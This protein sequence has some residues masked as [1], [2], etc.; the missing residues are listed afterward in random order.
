[1]VHQ[2]REALRNVP[3]AAEVVVLDANGART[4][5]DSAW[6]VSPFPHDTRTLPVVI[7]SPN[8]WLPVTEGD[9]C[10]AS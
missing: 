6:L 5:L 3:G 1:M 8:A 10:H 2:L 9:R 7:L 4:P